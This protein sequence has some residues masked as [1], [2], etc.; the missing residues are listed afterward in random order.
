MHCCLGYFLPLPGYRFSHSCFTLIHFS[1]LL[2]DQ[3]QT[4]I[5]KL[6][7]LHRSISPAID[8]STFSIHFA[9]HMSL[10]YVSLGDTTYM[11]CCSSLF[12]CSIHHCVALLYMIC[13][14]FS[15]LLN[16][17]QHIT[18]LFNEHR[19]VCKQLMKFLFTHML[20]LTCLTHILLS[21]IPYH[22]SLF[23]MFDVVMSILHFSKHLLTLIAAR[24]IYKLLADIHCN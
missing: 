16:G 13:S 7:W 18:L 17:S 14:I 11:S 24:R 6:Q 5:P 21:L 1:N 22:D 2:D 15:I 3:I 10:I 9:L 20:N 23:D 4:T 12:D 8:I 19:H